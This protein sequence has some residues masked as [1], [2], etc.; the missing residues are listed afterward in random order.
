MLKPSKQQH[1]KTSENQLNSQIMLLTTTSTL[2]DKKITAYYGL[3]SGES[4]IGA[5]IIKDFLAGIRDIVGGR[6]GSYERVLK[7]AKEDAMREMTAQAVALGANAVI[8]IDLDY[9]TVGGTMLMV[10][11]SGTAVKYE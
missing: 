6:S 10:T 1:K 8:G 5:N 2:Q 11:A 3:V 7:Q 4:V 9:E